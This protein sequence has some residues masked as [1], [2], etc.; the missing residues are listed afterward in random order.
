MPQV[1]IFLEYENLDISS[2]FAKEQVW[3]FTEI[4]RRA[5]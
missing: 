3:S 4:A 2:I 1:F 5:Y